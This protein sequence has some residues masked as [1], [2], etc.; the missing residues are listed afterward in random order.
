MS[1]PEENAARL[2]VAPNASLTW[3]HA[4]R[5]LFVVGAVAFGIAGWFAARGFWPVLVFAA[6]N[7]LALWAA[8][9]VCLRRNGYREVLSFEGDEIRVEIGFTGRGILF[10]AVLQRRMTRAMLEQGPYR[11]SPS[12]LLLRCQGRSIEI[13]QCLADGDRASLCR[14][15]RELLQPGWERPAPRVPGAIEEHV[16]R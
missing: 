7:L 9:A 3:Q 8:I 4:Q 15:I 6:L 14:R 1:G 5:F 10:E 2:V 12:Q 11:T 16:W 13:G